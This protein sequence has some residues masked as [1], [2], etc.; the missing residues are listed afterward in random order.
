MNIT[1]ARNLI[2]GHVIKNLG[3]EFAVESVRT[4]VTGFVVV[5]AFYDGEPI[6]LTYQANER[7][8]VDGSQG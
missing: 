7:V 6:R 1:A 2:P 5:Y 4:T 3:R 8:T